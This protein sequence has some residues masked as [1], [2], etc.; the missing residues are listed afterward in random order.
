M[1]FVTNDKCLENTLTMGITWQAKTSK[2]GKNCICWSV[3]FLMLENPIITFPILPVVN[4]KPWQWY[5]LQ[6]PEKTLLK[7]SVKI[8]CNGS[9]ASFISYCPF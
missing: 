5:H 6:Y 3:T 9:H 2:T 8:M 4:G 1:H 7:G